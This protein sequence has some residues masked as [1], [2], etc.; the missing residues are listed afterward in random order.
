MHNSVCLSIL[1]FF[2]S[3]ER[4]VCLVR[5]L[6]YPFVCNISIYICMTVHPL[7]M[8]VRLLSAYPRRTCFFFW[9]TLY[10]CCWQHVEVSARFDDIIFSCGVSLRPHFPDAAVRRSLCPFSCSM[11]RIQRPFCTYIK[12]LL[13]HKSISGI[14]SEIHM[15]L[16]LVW[17]SKPRK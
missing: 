3:C 10:I 17:I 16:V 12:E 14:F 1:P 2:L 9:N 7:S 11:G 8:A 5:L 6:F 4:A 15:I 13:Y